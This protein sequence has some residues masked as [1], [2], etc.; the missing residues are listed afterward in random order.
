[1]DPLIWRYVAVL[2]FFCFLINQNYKA[3][4]REAG[5]NGLYS[6]LLVAVLAVGP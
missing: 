2:L 1:M 3:I 4:V 5:Q 6:D